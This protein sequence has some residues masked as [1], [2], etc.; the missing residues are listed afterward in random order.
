M[1]TLQ[2]MTYDVNISTLCN[3][4]ADPARFCPDPDQTFEEKRIR[5][6]K[7]PGRIQPA[8]K[9]PDPDHTLEK[10]TVPGSYLFFFLSIFYFFLIF[11]AILS[12]W[13]TNTF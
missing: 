5:T 12:L 2:S 6:S 1:V 13:L 3:R 9:N 10:K 11:N 4:V 8:R 7:K